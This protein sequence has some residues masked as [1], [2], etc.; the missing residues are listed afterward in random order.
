MVPRLQGLESCGRWERVV[1]YV[2]KEIFDKP[3][4]F[5]TLDKLRRAVAVD[6]RLSLREIIEKSSGMIPRF[7]SKDELLEEEF[8]KFV[9]DCKPE[10]VK[11]LPALK[12][13]FK[14]YVTNGMVRD[15]IESKKF[16]A[17]YTTSAFTMEDLKAVPLKY[18]T[19]IP[20]YI[21]DYVSLNQ[22]VT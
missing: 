13:F 14:A 16:T 11:D 10:D 15:I 22:F 5:Y 2:N 12:N 3:A 7:K 21:K 19:L 17:L 4:E 18:R 20:E 1:D 6:R 9:S 8:A